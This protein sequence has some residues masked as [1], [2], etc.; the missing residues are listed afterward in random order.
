MFLIPNKFTPKTFTKPPLF[1]VFSWVWE[2]DSPGK[3]RDYILNKRRNIPNVY[4]G[5]DKHCNQC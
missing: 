4:A 5:N 3:G 1:L 2:A